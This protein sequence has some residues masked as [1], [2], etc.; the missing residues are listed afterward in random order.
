[1]KIVTLIEN[2]ACCDGLAAEHGLSLYIESCERR[3]LFDAGQ[4]DAF[5]DNAAALGVDLA[6]VDT[7]VLSHG[8]Y[9]HGGGLMRFMAENSTA[10]IHINEHAF[11]PYYNGTDKYIGLDAALK[12]SSRIVFTGDEYTIAPG[13]TLYSGSG[14]PQSYSRDAFGLTVKL[15]MS[16]V[17]DDFRHEQYLLIEEDGKR[18]LVSGCSH[19]GIVNI[20]RRF[21]PDVLIGGFHFTGL[22]PDG[23]Q[24]ERAARELMGRG[25]KYYTCHC[26]G[27][28]QY[29]R[30]KQ[31]MGE[32]IGYLAAGSR[33]EV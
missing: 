25:T 6:A 24:L 10:P 20:V 26:T 32:Q 11:G 7:A 17:D 33:I 2:T 31:L 1:M 9:D 3:I 15:G 19:K 23:P 22:D 21:E 4:S 16:F 18:V 5:A 8:H 13:L 27:A 30:L 14:V 12:G 28:A 29:R